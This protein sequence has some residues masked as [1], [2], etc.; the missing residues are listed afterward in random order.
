MFQKRSTVGRRISRGWRSS[1]RVI[2]DFVNSSLIKRLLI[3]STIVVAAA[4]VPSSPA[5][6]VKVTLPKRSQLTP[7]QRLNREGVEALRKRQN[8]KAEALFYKA[9]LFDPDDPFTLNNLGYVSEL[10]GQLDRAQRFYALASEQSTD[11]VIDE[12]TSK[13]VQ[14]QSMKDALAI[15]DGPM[16]TNHDNVEAARLLSL[17]RATEADLL[18][19]QTL[20]KDGHNVFTLNNLGVAKEMEGES[21][22][23]LKYYDAAAAA[24]SGAAAVVTESRAWRGKPA[25]AMAAQ[26][27]KLLR[28]RLKNRNSIAE[29][30]A[31]LNLRGVSAINR[32]D[33]RAADQDF[34]KAYA[35]DPYN[36]FALNNIGYVAEIE[37][38]R[39][40]AEFFYDNARQ[41]AGGAKLKVGLASS[42][43]AEGMQLSQVAA[44]SD[45]KVEAKVEQERDALRQ[46]HEPIV[47]RRRDNSPVE[48]PSQNPSPTNPPTQNPPQ[49]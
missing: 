41:A 44:D 33:L 47:L 45:T 37:G 43:S 2:G 12:A 39:E 34:R 15:P 16:Q 6:D 35:L 3:A 36:A 18:L 28:N 25:S 21:E 17:G 22:E 1:G 38:D 23:A 7:V 46:Q 42:R 11:A 30:V 13:R 49:R 24:H 8:G 9:Y 40:T 48:E 10:E 19:E 29:Q 20:K 31:E 26:N 14:G 32:N 4:C 27:A 5:A